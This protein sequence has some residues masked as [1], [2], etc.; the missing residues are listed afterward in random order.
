[1]LILIAEASW[2]ARAGD[3]RD[4]GCRETE[5]RKEAG[6]DGQFDRPIQL[7]TSRSSNRWAGRKGKGSGFDL[8]T[9][10]LHTHGQASASNVDVHC[11]EIARHAGDR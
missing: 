5:Y 6:G 8:V 11:L 10:A 3:V 2:K 4:P 7:L 1:M 9:Q